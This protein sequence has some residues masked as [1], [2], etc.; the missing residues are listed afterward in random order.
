MRSKTIFGALLVS[1]ALCSQGFGFE[2]LDRMLGLNGG[3]CG[4]CNACA[5]VAP[6]DPCAKVAACPAPCDKAACGQTGCGEGKKCRP[7]PVRD[8][9]CNIADMFESKG[10]QCEPVA[11][12]ECAAP[13]ACEPTCE[14]AKKCRKARCEK[15]CNPCEPAAKA[16]CEPACEK[17]CEPKCHKLYRRPVLELIEKL[18]C[19]DKNKCVAGCETG[20]ETG[21]G[22]TTVPGKAPAAA[23]AKAPEAAAPLPAAPKA[24][25]S[26]SIQSRSI[27]QGLVRN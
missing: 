2:L 7:T 23:P 11:V 5:K 21:C 17:P 26:A 27:Y 13:A 19:C 20:C 24:D 1:V 16:A 8:L 25:P 22:G 12:K 4:E 10:V 15:A 18:F 9:F 6:C 3:G 14:K